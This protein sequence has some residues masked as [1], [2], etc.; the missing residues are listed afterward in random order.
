MKELERFEG[1]EKR[2]IR[3]KRKCVNCG[4]RACVKF[5]GEYICENCLNPEMPPLKIDDFFEM[6]SM[7][8]MDELLDETSAGRHYSNLM[9]RKLTRKMEI[10][11]ISILRNN[12]YRKTKKTK[13]TGENE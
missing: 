4:R 13:E 12:K 11:G 8:G 3:L 10:I 1:Y 5:E 9:L 2:M 6:K 7:L